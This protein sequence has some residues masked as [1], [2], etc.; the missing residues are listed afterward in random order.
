MKARP[1]NKVK[2]S[3]QDLQ[4]R[5]I[6]KNLEV[7]GLQQAPACGQLARAINCEDGE[8]GVTKVTPFLFTK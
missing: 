1:L 7:A 6:N 4:N 8:G 2:A 3:K 5:E